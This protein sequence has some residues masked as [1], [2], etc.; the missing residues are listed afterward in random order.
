MLH[1]V[2]LSVLKKLYKCALVKKYYM[3]CTLYFAVYCISSPTLIFLVF[4][5]R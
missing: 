3:Y 4:L 1:A 5:G 2:V